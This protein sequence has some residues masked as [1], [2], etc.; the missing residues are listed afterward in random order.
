MHPIE[1][2]LS[3]N[4]GL[5]RTLLAERA[6]ISRMTLWRL[7]NGEGEFSTAVLKQISKATNGA[8]TVTQLAAALPAPKP[9]RRMTRKGRSAAN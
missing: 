1:Q 7:T 3:E 2:Y 4:P 8:V 6:G 5:T 9:A